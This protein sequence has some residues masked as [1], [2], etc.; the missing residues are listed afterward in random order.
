MDGMIV[1]EILMSSSPAHGA[2]QPETEAGEIFSPVGTGELPVKSGQPTGGGGVAGE[3]SSG[4]TD[5]FGNRREVRF[6]PEGF[7]VV[8][9]I[10]G[11]DETVASW[12]RGHQRGSSSWGGCTWQ[13][14]ARGGV[15]MVRG[16]LELAV[17]GGLV[18]PE[19]NGGGGVEEQ[20]R[21]S[22]RRL[23]ELLV[24]VRSSG[25]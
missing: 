4:V 14:G 2:F 17:R 10:G 13:R 25:W 22:A 19:R 8:E 9:G 12:S 1:D 16:W 5:R 11:R 15:E 3:Q 18:R 24:S 20:P 6:S 21:A 23:G 7:S